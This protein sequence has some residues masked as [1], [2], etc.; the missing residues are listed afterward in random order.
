MK[1]KFLLSSGIIGV[2][3]ISMT[4]LLFENEK[5]SNI[6]SEAIKCVCE[7][8]IPDEN[9]FQEANVIYYGKVKSISRSITG[10]YH[11]KVIKGEML[12]GDFDLQEFEITLPE[13][14]PF[15]F[16]ESK[17]YVF[18]NTAEK[19]NSGFCGSQIVSSD[20]KIVKELFRN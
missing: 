13:D 12:K 7:K 11:V 4:F 5:V 17:E 3:I 6:P 15:P 10:F 14:C 20:N 18:L 19:L 8:S 1:N 2:V 16:Q 9:D